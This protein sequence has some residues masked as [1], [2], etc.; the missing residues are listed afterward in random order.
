[1]FI[2]LRH[3]NELV[4]K[5]QLLP[6]SECTPRT[7]SDHRIGSY[8]NRLARKKEKEALWLALSKYALC[9]LNSK[10]IVKPW[11]VAVF[12]R[13]HRKQGSTADRTLWRWSAL[14]SIK[15][16]EQT[17]KGVTFAK[18]HQDLVPNLTAVSDSLRSIILNHSS[19]E[20]PDQHEW[21]NLP[22]KTCFTL[23]K[24]D[25]ARNNPLF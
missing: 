10:L 25:F 18:P 17:Q 20:F 22:D 19:L 1:M 3:K 7:Q 13:C 23:R 2:P 21:G 24:C 4:V 8:E 15:K 12:L 9:L 16:K 5:K 11:K 14:V 6:Q